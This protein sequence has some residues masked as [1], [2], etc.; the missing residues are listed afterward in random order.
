MSG[1]P[2]PDEVYRGVTRIFAT[3]ILAFGVTIIAVTLIH[4][5]NLASSG[6]WL[7]LLFLGLGA[8]R[9]Y[10]SMRSRD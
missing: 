8:G 4:G 3:I 1:P 6:I 9:L 5:G 10:I 7:G 2:P